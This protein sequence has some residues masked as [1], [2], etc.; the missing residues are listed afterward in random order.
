M[1]PPGGSRSSM[2]M[3]RTSYQ[4]AA[5]AGE[6]GRGGRVQGLRAR[7]GARLRQAKHRLLDDQHRHDT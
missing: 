7:C 4:V 6:G 2:G 1:Q 3:G 5:I